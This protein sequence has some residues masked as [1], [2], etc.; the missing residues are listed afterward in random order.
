M[1]VQ[2]N[3]MTA[4]LIAGCV[5]TAAMTVG[6]TLMF[7]LLPRWQQSPLPPRQ[8]TEGVAEKTGVEP[9]LSEQQLRGATML[10]HFGYGSVVGALY[11]VTAQRLTMPVVLKGSLFGL[12]VWA[13]GYYGWVPALRLLPSASEWPRGRKRL[14]IVAHLI[15]GITLAAVSDQVLGQRRDRQEGSRSR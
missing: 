7:R 12:T 11:G 14:M 1:S 5:G 8:I 6:M 15:W 3:P 13:G 4:G 2:R 10:A 9:Y